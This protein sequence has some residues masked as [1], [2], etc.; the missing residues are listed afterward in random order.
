R[1][2]IHV[3]WR[4]RSSV[5]RAFRSRRIGAAIARQPPRK[6]I[7]PE[8]NARRGVQRKHLADQKSAY[9][10]DA[11]RPAQLRSCAGAESERNAAEQRG[12]RGHHDRTETQQAGLVDRLAWRFAFLAL[13]VECEI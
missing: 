9:D 10:A 11:K 5:C 1:G 12:H 6:A 2:K 4:S 3:R 13:G 7:E 8:V